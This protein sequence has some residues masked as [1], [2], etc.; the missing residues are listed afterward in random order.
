MGDVRRVSV[1][2]NDDA[3]VGQAAL[4]PHVDARGTDIS[5]ARLD[6]FIG[7]GLTNLDG[8]EFVESLCKGRG[9]TGGHVLHDQYR[10]REVAWQACQNFL[11]CFRTPG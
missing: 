5:D 4:H 2:G 8:A 7:M 6:Q 3:K 10:H 11:K 1:Q 9:E